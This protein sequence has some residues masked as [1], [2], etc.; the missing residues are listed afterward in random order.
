M[1]ASEAFGPMRERLR[2]VIIM[3]ALLPELERQFELLTARLRE[4]KP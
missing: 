4:K 2:E 3:A 1:D